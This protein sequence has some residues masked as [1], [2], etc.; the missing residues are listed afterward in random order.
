MNIAV[1]LKKLAVVFAV[2]CLG[3]GALEFSR[4]ISVMGLF[5]CLV[6]CG[7]MYAL[8]EVADKLNDISESLRENHFMLWCYLKENDEH[9]D[10]KE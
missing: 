5:A 4:G 6:L 3:I 8:G 1:I 10:I 2:L 9:T 7:V